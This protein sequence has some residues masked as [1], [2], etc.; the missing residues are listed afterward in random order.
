MLWICTVVC[1]CEPCAFLTM[2]S[3]WLLGEQLNFPV[4]STA[5]DSRYAVSDRYWYVHSAY[6]SRELIQHD[7]KS[8]SCSPVHVHRPLRTELF[9]STHWPC[10]LNH[11]VDMTRPHNCIWPC[12][13]SKRHHPT[14]RANDSISCKAFE[15]ILL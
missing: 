9:P 3:V 6:T 2:I 8:S 13:H 12:L 4:R 10:T 1:L 15:G 7:Y 11:F 5:E 14:I